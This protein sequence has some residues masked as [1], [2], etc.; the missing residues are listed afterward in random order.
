MSKTDSGLNARIAV[1]V[2]DV[3]TI[4]DGG[5]G[6]R[7]VVVVRE[8]NGR[9]SRCKECVLVLLAKTK[10]CALYVRIVV[11]VV[12]CMCQ[13]NRVCSR[14]MLS[15]LWQATELLLDY[16]EEHGGFDW[17]SELE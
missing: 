16:G 10:D 12:Y 9:R 8:H 3:S 4:T 5:R 7:N 11:G 6:A 15:T 13:R 17:E 1:V 14:C 2:V